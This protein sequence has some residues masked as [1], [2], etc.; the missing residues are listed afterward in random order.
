MMIMITGRIKHKDLIEDYVIRL[1][2]ILGIDR[3]K[4]TSIEV[5]FVSKC[6]GDCYGLC[7]DDPSGDILIEIGRN[8]SCETLSFFERMQ[9]VAHEMV[10]AKQFLEFR[11]PYEKEAKEMEYELF[12]RAFPWDR[13]KF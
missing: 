8:T 2:Q 5:K 10:H 12:A 7:W 3:R 4:K 6:E 9:T 13:V 11:T 1:C